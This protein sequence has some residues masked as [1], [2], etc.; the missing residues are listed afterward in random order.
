MQALSRLQKGRTR[1][2]TR[3]LGGETAGQG[4][5]KRP[6]VQ[7]T[8]KL[9]RYVQTGGRGEGCAGDHNEARSFFSEWLPL[10]DGR[11][12]KQSV[13]E[14]CVI[15]LTLPGQDFVI[16]SAHNDDKSGHTQSMTVRSDSAS[17]VAYGWLVR[18]VV[19]RLSAM[20]PSS[21]F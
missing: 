5:F 17:D 9:R 12:K 20:T 15:D 1:K 10:N 7:A 16:D 14:K 21:K 18:F 6:V 8:E 11:E 2:K 3:K 13:D 19:R 4:R